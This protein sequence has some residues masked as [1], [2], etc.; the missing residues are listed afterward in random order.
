MPE[1]AD[2]QG[3]LKY[4]RFQHLPVSP[5]KGQNWAK[6][7]LA[8]CLDQSQTWLYLQLLQMLI[9]H[10]AV[11]WFHMTAWHLVLLRL[12][13]LPSCFSYM[14]LLAWHPPA[15]VCWRKK[16]HQCC[17]RSRVWLWLWWTL[18]F[19]GNSEAVRTHFIYS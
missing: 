18:W 12:H 3:C 16:W 6:R 10:H 11:D 2:V 4:S 19:L 13:C 5:S 7:V 15:E 14:A 17:Q 1:D 9:L 8:F